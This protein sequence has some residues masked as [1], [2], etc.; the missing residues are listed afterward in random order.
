MSYEDQRPQPYYPGGYFQPQTTGQEG[1]QY[2][3]TPYGQPQFG[4]QPQYQQPQ[5]QYYAPP[6]QA[7]VVVN[8]TQNNGRP[9]VMRQRIHHGRHALLTVLTGGLWAVVWIPLAM[10][11]NK[12][13][14]Y[15]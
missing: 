4:A 7:P 10:R 5:P 3:P 2:T 12:V 13:R 6:Q 1:T 14:V 15:R 9:L 11:A 8:V